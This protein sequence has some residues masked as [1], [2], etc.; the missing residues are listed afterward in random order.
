MRSAGAWSL[1]GS[2]QVVR[3]E[4]ENTRRGPDETKR[5]RDVWR[6]GIAG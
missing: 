2:Q 1:V 4:A 6:P 3:G 5:E